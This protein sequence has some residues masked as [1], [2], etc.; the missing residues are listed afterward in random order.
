MTAISPFVN[1][2]MSPS[3][4]V[5]STPV[6]IFGAEK[7]CLIDSILVTNQIDSTINFSLYISREPAYT[8]GQPIEYMLANTIPLGS[9]KRADVLEGSVLTCEAGDL[10]FAYSNF[11]QSIFNVFVSYRELNEL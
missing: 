4:N 5:G 2:K 6:L 1:F 10:M 8:S 3:L 11:S 9:L 7:T